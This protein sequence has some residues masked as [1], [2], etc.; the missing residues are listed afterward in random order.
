MKKSIDRILTTH[1]GSLPRPDDVCEGLYARENGE[2]SFDS[3]AFAARVRSATA[4]AVKRQVSVGLDIVS[5][6]EMSK[7]TYATYI[8]DR[9]SGFGG[10]SPPS[11]PAD[12]VAFPSFL[13]RLAKTGA[14]PRHKRP[15]CVGEVKL[16]NDAPL[17]ADIASMQA[18]VEDSRPVE[19]F[20]NSASPGVIAMFQPALLAINGGFYHSE[21]AYLADLSEA[22]RSEYEAIAAA[23]LILQIDSP[24]LGVGRH[25]SPIIDDA[26]YL[27]A[28]EAHL[29]ALN[30]ALS[31]PEGGAAAADM[32]NFADAGATMFIA[33]D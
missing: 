19:G 26:A 6:G 1:V 15:F 9:L 25:M 2:P 27:R 24:D 20:M 32:A 3:A 4:E 28:C 12:L 33:Y 22:M 8:A 18:A 16:E 31:S 17:R 29:E 23:G 10:E 7:I 14:A 5:D 21:D 30:A 13:I 11:P